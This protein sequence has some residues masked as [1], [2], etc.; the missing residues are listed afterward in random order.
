M[1][2]TIA[3][4]IGGIMMAKNI[5]TTNPMIQNTVGSLIRLL[6][7]MALPPHILIIC[8]SQDICYLFN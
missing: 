5:P 2:S 6:K 8:C 3:I 7:N 1:P 4:I